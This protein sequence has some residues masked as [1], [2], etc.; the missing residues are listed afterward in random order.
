MVHFGHP[1]L[2]L[3]DPIVNVIVAVGLVVIAVVMLIDWR[4]QKYKRRK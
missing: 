2:S 3:A 4:M 1:P